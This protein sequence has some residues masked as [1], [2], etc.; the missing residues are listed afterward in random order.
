MAYTKETDVFILLK[1]DQFSAE[2]SVVAKFGDTE[3]SLF[4][5]SSGIE[6]VR[7]SGP[8]SSLVV[9]PF[10]GHQ[11]WRAEFDGVEI[12]M[13][14]M[15]EEPVPTTEF[16]ETYGAFFVHCG[17]G[18]L[19]D[20]GPTDK[21]K[22]HGELP[23]APF[24][25]AQLIIR[26]EDNTIELV[27]SYR[28]R[29]AFT[30]NYVATSRITVPQDKPEIGLS[31]DVENNRSTPMDLMYLA[32]ANFRPVDGA[33]LDYSAEYTPECVEIRTSI[34]L[35][36][37]PPDGYEALI[38]ELARNPALHHDLSPELP[39]DPEVVFTLKMIADANGWAHGMQTHPDGSADFISY[40]TESLPM[41]TRWLCRTDDQQGLGMVMPATS[42]VEGYTI[43]KSK[44]RVATI[45][46]HGHWTARMR[47]GRL[48]A[49]E[50]DTLRRHIDQIAGRA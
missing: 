42:G 29:I 46:G 2:D 44:G 31:L 10:F 26:A 49:S 20:P 4:R 19:G 34:P 35:H 36:I 50:A 3:I 23:L 45:P 8:R 5:Y 33:R 24:S 6:A 17:L 32:H 16:L 14:S 28:R 18:G 12:S 22:L 7:I 27:G 21:H 1:P 37:S 39:F 25:E 48:N 11:I 40:D 30:Q 13:R 41:A 47:M 38:Q 9:L 15:F 43:E